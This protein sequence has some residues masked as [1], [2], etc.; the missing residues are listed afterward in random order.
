MTTY[1]TTYS[2]V[3]IC[4]YKEGLCRSGKAQSLS[5][6][7]LTGPSHPP[8]T[9]SC[10]RVSVTP[11][12]ALLHSGLSHPHSHLVAHI[13]IWVSVTPTHT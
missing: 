9:F 5:F 2:I 11:T 12:H 13:H 4:A 3:Y 10:T 1:P 6:H 7:L 8:L